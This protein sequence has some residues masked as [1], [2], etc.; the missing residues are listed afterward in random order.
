MFLF[1]LLLLIGVVIGSSPRCANLT[2]F[3]S[4]SQPD[5]TPIFVG[6]GGSAFLW[7][8]RA[9]FMSSQYAY[10]VDVDSHGALAIQQAD[11]GA[12]QS[13]AGAVG[14]YERLPLVLH[15][16]PSGSTDLH[17]L[18]IKNSL[19]Y[20]VL[21]P[22]SLA[23]VVDASFVPTVATTLV[24]TS[25]NTIDVFFAS[26]DRVVRVC[27]YGGH[28]GRN[29]SVFD[30]S[31]NFDDPL[32]ADEAFSIEAD[33]KVRR[34]FIARRQSG[35]GPDDAADVLVLKIPAGTCHIVKDN[36]VFVQPQPTRLSVPAQCQTSAR[37]CIG[38][39][40]LIRTIHRPAG[41][42]VGTC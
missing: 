37:F 27:P 41:C 1:W 12:F 17:F 7:P 30:L 14:V 31:A 38:R 8:N 25:G 23:A 10:Q 21:P 26:A 5:P 3:G 40:A 34:I 6:G 28:N 32:G 19:L 20:D 2:A 33:L 39:W 29:A 18:S 35:S 13:T 9:L 42:T 22:H 15:V 16:I 24:D 11:I 4:A 36:R